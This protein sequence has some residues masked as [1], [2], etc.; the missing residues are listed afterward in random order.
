[1]FLFADG[2]GAA[3]AQSFGAGVNNA[4]VATPTIG[5]ILA[6]LYA[7]VRVVGPLVIQLVQS[8][9]TGKPTTE[10]VVD[11]SFALW[12]ALSKRKH[13]AEWYA[14]LPAEQRASLAVAI[15]DDIKGD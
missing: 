5:M 14:A 8:I 2:F 12:A 13:V 1:M 11:S 15:M 3:A 4:I 10:T 7:A 9:G 6:G